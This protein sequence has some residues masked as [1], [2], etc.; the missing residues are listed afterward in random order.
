MGMDSLLAHLKHSYFLVPISVGI[1]VALMKVDE[2]LAD[3]EKPISDYVKGIVI[4]IVL[5]LSF[6]YIHSIDESVFEVAQAGIP[7]F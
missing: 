4:T 2:A 3:T 6:L 7:S 5:S 1:V